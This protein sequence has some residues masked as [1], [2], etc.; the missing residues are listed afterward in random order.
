MAQAMQVWGEISFNL[1]YLAVVWALVVAMLRRRPHLPAERQR[2]A[3]LF[4][5]AF[6]LLAAWDT[7]HVGFRVL[8]YALGDLETTFNVFGITVGLVGLGVFSTSVTVT[9]FY[10]LMLMIWR[11][12]FDRPY[13]WLGVLAFCAAIVRLGIMLLPQNEWSRIVSPQPWSSYRNAPLLVQGSVAAILILRDAAR[14]HDR[15]F[16]WIGVMILISFAF[17]IPVILWVEKM[18]VIGMLMIPKTMTYVVMAWLGY[19]RVFREPPAKLI[20]N[21]I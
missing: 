12:R 11:Q 15:A 14:N 6:A 10:A 17:Y 9:L 13:G 7:G 18:P 2:L 4:I 1:V 8:A 5:W 19:K 21:P 16:K 3:Q 20:E